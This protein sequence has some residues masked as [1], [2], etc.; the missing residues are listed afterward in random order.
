MINV[1]GIDLRT[2]GFVAVR[3]RLPRLGGERT[4]VQQIPGRPGGIR[5]G[6]IVEPDTLSVT[7]WI[8]GDSHE[9]LLQRLDLLAAT[10][11]GECVIRL[12]DYPD[13]EWVGWLQRGPSRAVA[14]GPAWIT[15]V[16]DVTLEWSLPDPSARAQAESTRTGS[17]AITLGTAPSP[18]R[19]EVQN[20]DAAA[21]TRVRVRVR[22][23]G[24]SGD[25][26][27][28]LDWTGQ[29]AAGAELVIDADRFA[30]T[31]DDANVIDGLTPESVFPVADPARGAD[32]VGVEVTGGGGHQVTVRY[33]RR[34]V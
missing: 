21:I 28:D 32:Y 25:V 6:G 30:V 23:G 12:D 31:V 29:V 9:D 1:N 27:R 24:S 34:W 10:L 7:G 11:R 33:R 3:R 5:M 19:V 22:A 18:I 8:A 20:G 26:L 17:G 16:A 14:V 4:T 2:L 15:P 13:R